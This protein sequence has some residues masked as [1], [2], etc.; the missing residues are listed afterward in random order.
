MSYSTQQLAALDSTAYR[1]LARRERKVLF[2]ALRIARL[3]GFQ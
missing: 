2:L 3:V 1:I